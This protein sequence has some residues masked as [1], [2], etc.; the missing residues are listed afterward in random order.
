MDAKKLQTASTTAAERRPEGRAIV[1]IASNNNN[2]TNTITIN[3]GT[4]AVAAL[5]A[6]NELLKQQ[7]AKLWKMLESMLAK[8]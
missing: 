4:A 3:Q 8:D 1:V 6:E 7:N 2:S 5:Q